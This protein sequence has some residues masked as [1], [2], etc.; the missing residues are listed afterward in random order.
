MSF[1]RG[2]AVFLL[3]TVFIASSFAA[4][5]LFNIGPFLQKDSLSGFI[6]GQCVKLSAQSC[7]EQCDS[8]ECEFEC[9]SAISS[10]LSDGV[11]VAVDDLY[12]R[13]FYGVS[14]SDALSFSLFGVMAILSAVS[15]ALL[16]FAS[17]K[18]LMTL[19]KDMTVSS[20]SVM[21]TPLVL[22]VV[23]SSVSLPFD[24]GASFLTYVSMGLSNQTF[25]GLVM[26]LIGVLLIFLNCASKR[27]KN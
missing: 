23:L 14:I 11:D 26:L 19:G 27:R 9:S 3:S 18:P 24:I 10:Q 4:I 5:T 22:G 8:D 17:K 13:R 6:V 2:L 1:A 25:S 15:A 12:D 7:Q 21:A 16:I 20:V